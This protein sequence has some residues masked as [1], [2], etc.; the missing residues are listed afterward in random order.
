MKPFYKNHLINFYKVVLPFAPAARP[1]QNYE[2]VLPPALAP[3]S[4]RT[5]AASQK[6]DGHAIQSGSRMG[7]F[8]L[9][10][11]RLYRCSQPR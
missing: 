11:V 3:R 7:L 8:L 6:V 9:I 2:V 10:E 5:S 1:V 4:T